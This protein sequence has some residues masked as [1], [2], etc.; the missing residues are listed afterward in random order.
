MKVIQ[1]VHSFP[2][3]IG[4]IEAHVSNLSKEMVKNGHEVTV[5]TSSDG[6]SPNFEVIDGIRVFRYWSLRIPWF[7]SVR[8][9]PFLFFRLLLTDGDI[10]HSHG[11]GSI[12]P[13][14]T[15]IAAWLKRK[16]FIFTLHGYPKLRGTSAIMKWFYTNT[17]A[18]IFLFLSRKVIT[19]TRATIE[20]IARETDRKKICTIPNG[21]DLV[22]FK[23]KKGIS[24]LE[25]TDILYIGRFDAYKGIDTLIR[26]F[27]ILR[28][29]VPQARLRI[30]GHDEG[31]RGSLEAISKELGVD[32]CFE[33]VKPD[34]MAQVYSS[35]LTVVLPSK[36]EGLSLVLLETISSERPMLS[37]PVGAAKELFEEIYKEEAQRMLF[38]VDD[39]IGLAEKLF[40][41]TQD[42][43]RY[44]KLCSL[45]RKRLQVAYSWEAASVKT[46]DL[47]TELM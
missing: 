17:I 6:R 38:E 40:D 46:I 45:A 34:D 7:S 33:E 36:Y 21:V 31:I 41:I 25:A 10:Y 16:P 8:I 23:S 14:Y 20:D 35:A 47:Y 19:V 9:I 1:V 39:H 43:G 15:A 32:V 37:T 24:K 18:R 12:Q 5:I 44:E 42:R 13:F 11:Y 30:I 29:R 3:E 27:A 4:G 28:N 26:A 22:K 2:P